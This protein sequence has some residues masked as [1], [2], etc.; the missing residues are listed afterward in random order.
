MTSKLS[1]IAF[2]PFSVAAIA[3]EIIRLFFMDTNGMLFI[4]TTGLLPSS[5]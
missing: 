4:V 3:I 5:Q 2:A 1:F